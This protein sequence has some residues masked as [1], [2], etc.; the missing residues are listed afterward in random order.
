MLKYLTAMIVSAAVVT[1]VEAAESAL[2]TYPSK[3]VRIIVGFAPGGGIDTIARMASR[4]FSESLGQQ[5]IVD[6][7]PGASGIIG[8]DLVAKAAP[9]GYTLLMTA[10]VHTITPGMYDKL[11]FD[12]IKDFSPVGTFASGPQCIAVHPSLPAQSLRELILLSKKKPNEVSYASAGGGTLTHVAVE[13]FASMAGIKLLHVP[14]KGSGPSV[15]AAI[16]GEVPVLS[17]ALGQALPHAGMGRLRVLAVTSAERTKLAPNIPAIAEVAN[18]KGY[19]SVSWLGLLAPA[20]TPPAIVGRINAEIGRQLQLADV[21]DQFAGRA[22]V[23]YQQ[24]PAVFAEMIKSDIL[25]WGKVIR[26]SGIKSN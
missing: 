8:A 6:N 18:L 25:K 12:P 9:D 2:P 13:L 24:S 26:D 4:K 16:G 7:R 10:D 22:W 21:L 19:E 20:G 1:G 23:P 3:P 15:V 5:F 17:I 11:P 14:Y